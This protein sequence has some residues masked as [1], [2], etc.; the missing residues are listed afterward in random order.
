MKKLILMIPTAEKTA[1][2]IAAEANK[3]MQEKGFLPV[4]K[5][6]INSKLRHKDKAVKKH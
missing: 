4:E 1:E 5:T 2:Q 3:I 6:K